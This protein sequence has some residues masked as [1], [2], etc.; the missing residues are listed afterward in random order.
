M[1]ENLK[2]YI[3]ILFHFLI[4]V[5]LLIFENNHIDSYP[6]YMNAIVAISLELFLIFIFHNTKY[7]KFLKRIILLLLLSY[8]ILIIFL[9]Y[10][11]INYFLIT[12]SGLSFLS[13]IPLSIYL[14]ILFLIRKKY[15]FLFY[16]ILNLFWF[17]F[18]LI[19]TSFEKFGKKINALSILVMCI[20]LILKAYFTKDKYYREPIIF[21]TLET[22]G[23]LI[24]Y[25]KKEKIK[26]LEKIIG[27]YLLFCLF[28]VEISSY[29]LEIIE[30]IYMLITIDTL[31][32]IFI[33]LICSIIKRNAF[34]FGYVL[35]ETFWFIIFQILNLGGLPPELGEYSLNPGDIF[36]TYIVIINA[37]YIA[38]FYS[39]KN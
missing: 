5:C 12:I 37:L 18:F 30:V 9:D 20:L 3:F 32:L 14:F 22:F 11:W 8:S 1:R 26:S 27:E 25:W 34:L 33:V 28:L 19:L 10:S 29:F 36:L 35:I 13:G 17:M 38:L 2:N 24:F 39:K 31:I 6:N 4:I 15:I 23:I 21:I 16:T 7:L